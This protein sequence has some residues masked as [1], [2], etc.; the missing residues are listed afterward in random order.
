[1][2][3]A[4]SLQPNT[5]A[6]QLPAETGGNFTPTVRLQ[7]IRKSAESG[8]LK[9]KELAGARWLSNR[10]RGVQVLFPHTVGRDR[11]RPFSA[12]LAGPSESS[13]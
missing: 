1:M 8:F 7:T 10:R 13:A 6:A 11:W 12:A 4:W 3:P 5:R 9:T 2:K